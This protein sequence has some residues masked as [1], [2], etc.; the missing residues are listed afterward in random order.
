MT[1]TNPPSDLVNGE[2]SDPRGDETLRRSV[3]QER[4]NEAARRRIEE[5]AAKR[6]KH[7]EA[8]ASPSSLVQANTPERI[9]QRLD[10][11]T[12]YN[13]G[14]E[15]PE[16]TPT[17]S[18][19]QLLEQALERNP[20]AVAETTSAEKLLEA[21]INTNDF[22]GTRYLDAG[23]AAARAV[24]RILIKDKPRTARRVW[25]RVDDLAAPDD[26]QPS[27]AGQRAGR[28][29]QPGRVRLPG[30]HRRQSARRH[31]V[32]LR[33]RPVLH[34]RRGFGFRDRGRAGGGRRSRP[35]R[36]QPAD[37]LRRHGAGRR[38][39]HNRAASTRRKEAGRVAGEP[40]RRPAGEVS[41][42]TRPTPS[43]ARRAHRCSTTSGKSLRCTT[44]AC[45]LPS[46]PSSVA[47]STRASGCRR[48]S[49]WS[50]PASCRPISARWPT[51]S[52]IHPP[53]RSGNRYTATPTPEASSPISIK[54]PLTLD[55]TLPPGG[56]AQVRVEQLR[57]RAAEHRG[58][59]PELRHPSRL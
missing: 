47:C 14:D 32:R 34:R 57:R 4:Q 35:V 20:A 58:H 28:R 40:H 10:R 27:R 31:H 50:R 44:R 48:S 17:A 13:A 19:E 52:C 43:P 45:G 7:E 56:V 36:V 59:R 49:A 16:T 39:R 54:I 12:R 8:L 51:R 15:L 30:W 33:P 22:V 24:G 25:H 53:R 21:I 42:T 46:T 37:R 1:A 9:A 55:V 3:L 26:D 11:I 29:N 2:E 6:S 18:P 23:V 5:R 41:C 38:V